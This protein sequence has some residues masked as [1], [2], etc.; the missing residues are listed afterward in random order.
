MSARDHAIGWAVIL[1]A[2]IIAGA[3]IIATARVPPP[4]PQ[5]RCP[6]A[7]PRLATPGAP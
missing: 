5:P 6:C 7:T 1:A 4:G 3:A 2:A